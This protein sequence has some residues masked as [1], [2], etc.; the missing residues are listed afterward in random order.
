MRIPAVALR[1]LTVLPGMVVHFDV[2]RKKS[3]W[4]VEQAMTQ[5]QQILMVTQIDENCD[6]PEMEDL[7]HMGTLGTIKQILK[8]P[9]DVIRVLAEGKE[10]AELLGLDSIHGYLT[11]EV[12]EAPVE[13]TP[14]TDIEREA[15][16]RA[17]K[18]EIEVYGQTN[19]NFGTTAAKQVSTC[20]TLEELLKQLMIRFPADAKERMEFL[21]LDSTHMQFVTLMERM[22]Q[23]MEAVRLKQEIQE[24]VKARVDKNQREYLIREEIKV[25]REE[26]G[27]DNP[28]KESDD[29]N[30]KVDEL[31]A[32]DAVK[33]QIRKE[34]KRLR[35]MPPGSQEGAVLRTYIETVLELPWDKVTE[36][37]GDIRE[38]QRILDEDHYGL[39]D[40]KERILEHLSVRILSGNGGGTILCLVGPPGTGKT[41]IAKSIA[42]A[43][44]RKY[45]RVCLGGVHDEAEI[46]GHRR[47]YVGSM[48][49]RI[50]D[51]MK[52]AG[53]SNPLMLLDEIDKVSSDYKGDVSSA[54]LEVLDS[55][56]NSH[57]ADHYVE[58]PLDLSRV[59]FI[60]TANTTATIPKPLLDRMEM[61]EVSGYTEN[62]KYHIAQDYLVEK[63]RVQNGLGEGQITISEGAIRK[64]I[65]NYTREAGVR[66]LERRI[67]QICRKSARRI[68]E[69]SAEH[70]QVEAEDLQ[71]LLGK[72]RVHY[73]M[74][75]EFDQVGIVR[76][77]AWTA[78]GGDTLEIEVNVMPG[79]GQIQL[80][81]QMGDV[82]K[83][84]AQIGYSYIRSVAAN[85]DI[86]AEY[87]E[88][89]DVHIH[90]PEGAVPKDGPSAGITMATAMLSAMTDRKVYADLAMTGE[91]TLRGRVLPI[92]G[93][94]E[95]L[96]AAKMA[97]IHH[98]LV[99]AKN[100]VDVEE[101]SAEIT[102]GL[103]I[104]Y[105]SSM[106]EVIDR[107]FA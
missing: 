44:N 46:R 48:P 51:G 40:I 95:K 41:S 72:E 55:E 34:I 107:A 22:E 8:L 11:A 70:I 58:I 45:V 101:L 61:I 88:K 17:L 38:A 104:V 60:A 105:V 57:F 75:N 74:A 77:L 9:G 29:L 106:E 1:G 16:V 47:T 54:M 63:Q 79:K 21:L 35:M 39:K 67:G 80:T 68:L 83:E 87:F 20:Q 53:T 96:L 37:S 5:D 97:D 56:Q 71:D 26:L 99:P 52:K 82:M 98:V 30:Q 12:E 15:M 65:H 76:G 84:S 24:K 27:E 86:A 103:E 73:D 85:Y 32:K 19:K 66:N 31:Q 14:F 78:V 25:L 69:E 62:E 100:R 102:D 7:Y 59:L 2:S 93:L 89:H 42:R 3:I 49:G 6:E 91:V 94:K 43:L 23:D 50:A 28:D 90:I 33:D 4:A 18:S 36:E 10:R 64:I 92:G 81:G 13:Q